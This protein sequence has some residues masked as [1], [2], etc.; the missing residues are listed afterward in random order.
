[1]EVDGFCDAASQAYEMFDG[2]AIFDAEFTTNTQG[3][4]ASKPRPPRTTPGLPSFRECATFWR[5]T[6]PFQLEAVGDQ[7]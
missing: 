2:K 1:L 4:V 7:R 6:A 5:E 3:I